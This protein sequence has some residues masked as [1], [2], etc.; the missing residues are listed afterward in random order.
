MNARNTKIN[1]YTGWQ[2]LVLI[3]TI[4]LLAISA[5]PN[6]YGE[7]AAI[8]IRSAVADVKTLDSAELHQAL[9]EQGIAVKKITTDND[10]STILLQSNEQQEPAQQLLKKRLGDNYAVAM[11]MQSAAPQ[12]LTEIGMA[13]IKLGLDLRGGVQ[14]LLDV[15]TDVAITEH[16]KQI[17][18]DASL[19]IRE[20][21]LYGAK[22]KVV[23]RQ[24][25]AVTYPESSFDKMATVK[26]ELKLRYPD[27]T[28]KRDSSTGFSLHFNEKNKAEFETSIIK[29][30]L[31]TLRE[32]IEE[33]GITEAVTQRQGKNRIRIELPGVQDPTE[34]KRIIGATASL[35]FYEL[36]EVG[37]KT[38]K[39]QDGRTVNL[40][41]TP[42]LAGT[43]IKDARSGADDMGM[44]EVRLVLDSNGGKKMAK[45][46]KKNIGNPMVTVFSEFSKND[47]GQSVKKSKVINMATIT[48]NLGT[49]F[50]ITNMGS[51]KGAAE[52]ALLLRAGSLTAPV[53]IVAQSSIGPSLGQ[54]NI[55]NGMAALMLGMGIILAFMALWY[56]RLGFVA[57]TALIFN[58]VCLLGLM[59]LIPG[60]VLTMPGI[61]GLVLTVGMAVDTNVLI[62]ERIKEERRR[63]RS[64]Q[65]AVDRGYSN[66]FATILDANV[67]TMITAMILYTVGYGPVK[68][69]AIT[70]GLGLLTSMFTGVFAS[71]ALVNLMLAK[72]DRLLKGITA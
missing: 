52:L 68:G 38:F 47:K 44:P 18:S 62:F 26:A 64:L 66:A 7:N 53:T 49:R 57:N 50:S 72:N 29:Q 42:I 40:N 15:D 9:T 1:R 46:S 31:H 21:H 56:R 20:A 48:S 36:K 4:A 3:V 12:W 37:G 11:A 63:G 32:R 35:D 17:K 70:L 30:N 65:M 28:Q 22:V 45:H 24:K 67:T 69:F 16:L 59:S 10:K 14:F 19:L 54:D 41:P 27:L 55:E 58:L 2:Y 51:A 13:P 8:N 33:L 5:L 60:A 71:R 6:I 43:H 39:M 23:G 61:A 34:A 25:I